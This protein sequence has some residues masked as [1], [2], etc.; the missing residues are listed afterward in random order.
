MHL[1]PQNILRIDRGHIIYKG[2]DI[3][4]YKNKEMSKVRGKEISMIFQDSMTSLN[5][6][7]TVGKQIME[8]V[9]LNRH[10]EKRDAEKEALDLLTKVGLS[11]P[12]KRLK[13]YPHQLSGG[14]R[15]RVMIAMALARHPALI[16]A[17]EPTTAL[18]VTIQAQ[19][20]ELLKD[21]KEKSGA[22]IML[23]THD[24]GVVADM[25]DKI[26]VMYAG[27]IMEYGSASELFKNPLHP[28]TKGLLN[29]IPRK[30]RDVDRLFTIE[31]TVPTLQHMPTGCRFCTRCGEATPRCRSERPEM[32]RIGNRH[33]R[34]WKY[35]D[36]KGGE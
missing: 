13:E 7:M 36:L 2:Q 9:S 31:G 27:M 23:I 28:Y 3:T 18:D 34:C 14:M 15:Q 22:S 33:V 29:S 6:V 8:A 21:L 5:P 26:M 20:L 25:A 4:N 17:D 30:D 24:M 10:I 16:I 19:I 12:E 1:L 32:Y 35:A 11:S